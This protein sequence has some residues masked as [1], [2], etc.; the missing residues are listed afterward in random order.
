MTR[1]TIC[2]F[3][4]SM[5]F[6]CGA[7]SPLPAGEWKQALEQRSWNFPR[8]HGAHPDY[9][10]EW[11]YFT[12]NLTDNKGDR[13]GYQLTFFRQGIQKKLKKRRNS[14]E[15]RDVYFAHFGISDIE[16]KKFRFAE[17]ISRTG[18]GLAGA[19]TDA[20]NAWCLDWSVRTEK[21]K[22]FI[23]AGE[24]GMRLNLRLVPQKPLVIHGKNGLSKKGIRP[25]QASYYYSFTDLKTN[26]HL[27]TSENN[28][29]IEIK[30]ISWFD[31]EFGSNQLSDDQTGWD[32]FSVHLSDGR[33]LM[34]Y[35]LRRRDATLEKASS[36][37]LIEKN[38]HHRHLALGD[39]QRKV[40]G[41]WTSPASKGRYPNQWM[42][43][44][45]SVDIDLRLATMIPDQELRTADST[46]I[47]YYEGAIA[48]RGTSSGKPVACEGYV[49]MTGYAGALG[50]IF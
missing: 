39:I 8:D 50:G 42:I 35:F 29:P 5:F 41:H 34:L 15:V 1:F 2:L 4:S 10:T 31:H 37:T 27:M 12:G 13:Y 44:I 16:N 24:G 47:V 43:K 48:G 3:I 40:L 49:E 19:A 33:D 18:P 7:F 6:L 46:G 14:W 9:R 20:L 17:R 11:W 23:S 36:G 21:E 25:G 26:G 22:T 32:W 38:G 30:G 28:V 45:P